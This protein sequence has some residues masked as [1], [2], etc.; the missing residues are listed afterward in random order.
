M[1]GGSAVSLDLGTRCFQCKVFAYV[2][3]FDGE[4]GE[5]GYLCMGCVRRA[6]FELMLGLS[7]EEI[8]HRA[9]GAACA[10]KREE[11]WDAVDRK[12]VS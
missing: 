1:S 6:N 11:D 8:V 3:R 2:D 7:E 5:S 9:V 12:D 10:H 4:Y